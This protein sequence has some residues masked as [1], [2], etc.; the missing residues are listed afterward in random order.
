MCN[1]SFVEFVIA[2]N[3]PLPGSLSE[4][5][6][7]WLYNVAVNGPFHQRLAMKVDQSGSN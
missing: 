3:C 5:P 1:L 7:N 6:E 2:F 4:S